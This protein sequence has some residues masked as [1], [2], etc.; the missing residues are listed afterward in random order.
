LHVNCAELHERRSAVRVVNS[1]RQIRMPPA[2]AL[3]GT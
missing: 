3:G 1:P 2:S